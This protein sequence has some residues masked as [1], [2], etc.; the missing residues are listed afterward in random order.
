MLRAM[1]RDLRAHKGRIAMTLVAIVLGVSFVVATWVVADSTAATLAGAGTR[2]DVGVSVQIKDRAPELTEADRNRLAAIPGVERAEGTVFGRA[3][4]IGKDG[5]L[6]AGAP[7]TAGTEWD[8]TQRFELVD[9]QAPAA[10]EVA[11]GEQQ[12]RES[13]WKVGDSA[14][15][16]LANGTENHA[17]V[18]GVFV[19]R[20]LGENEPAV[21]FGTK[22]I[23]GRSFTRIELNG[24]NVDAIAAAVRGETDLDIR[25]VRTGP[26]LE[27]EARARAKDSADTGRESLMGFAAVALLVGMFVI[28]NTFT[29]LVTQRTRQLALLRAVG[30]SRRQVRRAVLVEAGVLGAIGA[31][32]GVVLGIGLALAA[33]WVVRP[34][35]ETISFALSPSA[36]LVGYAVGVLVTMIA[37]Y[38]SARRAAA[39]SPMAALGTDLAIP[40]RSLRIRSILGATALLV[41]VITTVATL[42]NNL[43]TTERVV[44]MGGGIVGWLGVLFLAPLLASAALKPL[45]RLLSRRGGPA[46]RLGMRNSV[47]DPRRTA[48][49]T[50]ALMVGLALVCSFATLGETMVSMLTSSIRA[51]VP[52]A[53]VVLLSP[54]KNAPLATDVLDKVRA[55]PGVTASAERYGYVKVQHNGTTSTTTMSAIE[56]DGVLTP[57]IVEGSG[58]IRRGA[59]VGRNEAAMLGL[60]V[61]DKVSVEI[62]PVTTIEVTVAGLYE[63]TEGQPLFYVDV[64]KIPAKYRDTRV[65]TVYALNVDKS[66]VEQAFQ[67]RPDVVVTDQQGLVDSATSSFR[68]LLSV[69]YAL[70]GAAI[71]IAA[72]GVVNTLALS[73]TERTREIGVLRAVGASQSLIRRSVRLES[74]VICGY[75]GLL[76]IVVGLAFGAVMQHAMLGQD[77]W[78]ISVPYLVIA[79]AL[80]G[81]ILVGV[82]AAM[83]PARRAARTNILAAIATA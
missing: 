9:G 65:T 38:A 21:A 55:L 77:L 59:V 54:T 68:L 14:R 53:S 31:T 76:G 3:A 75:G 50:S 81:M 42:G 47:R 10:G 34:E 78:R 49:T 26:E 32:L 28:A 30:A 41:A 52:A 83:W 5:K 13:G 63:G 29:M 1:L 61:G 24:S 69:M 72:F 15:I 23:L 56:P 57:E 22:G 12:A 36:I 8:T 39:V 27:A 66:L 16:L 70:F 62:D 40:R 74:I 46:M 71:V 17:R 19:Y 79:T 60:G 51:T 33:M 73:V 25:D 6:T 64:A 48:A 82:L 20:S 11:L 35:G 44:N 7:D 67:D 4:L 43:S 80:A 37:A 58:D 2:T 45:G 18:A